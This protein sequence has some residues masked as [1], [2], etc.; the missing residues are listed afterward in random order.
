MSNFWKRLYTGKLRKKEVTKSS[1]ISM[2]ARTFSSDKGYH[3]FVD[4]IE[5]GAY[6]KYKKMLKR[7]SRK[8]IVME[9][10][11]MIF[12]SS[13]TSF[14]ITFPFQNI[15]LFVLCFLI[16]FMLAYEVTR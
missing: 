9:L 4:N 6:K 16:F 11:A 14:M 3:K 13:I 5:W 2:S 7:I 10:S 8:G 12:S 15:I 1:I